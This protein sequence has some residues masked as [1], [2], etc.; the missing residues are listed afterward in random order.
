MRTKTESLAVQNLPVLANKVGVGEVAYL[1]RRP[2]GDTL[3][4]FGKACTLEWAARS[5]RGPDWP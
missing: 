3:P 4:G 1:A 5:S 2:S